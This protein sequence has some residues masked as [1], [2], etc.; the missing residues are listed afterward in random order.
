MEPIKKITYIFRINNIKTNVFNSFE[1]PLKCKFSN[2]MPYL[3][4]I[5]Q[6]D[7]IYLLKKTKSS[8]IWNDKMFHNVVDLLLPILIMYITN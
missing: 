5:D 8:K 7:C 4:T 1:T 3:I 6:N 2:K